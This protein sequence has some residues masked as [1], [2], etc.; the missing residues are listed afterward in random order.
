MNG[1][2]RKRGKTS[3]ELRYDLPRGADGKRRREV[4]GV[5]PEIRFDEERNDWVHGYEAPSLGGVLWSQ[6]G[7]MAVGGSRLKRW[8][9]D[10][11][12]FVIVM[13]GGLRIFLA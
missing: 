12:V 1:S 4:F 5:H 9:R 11:A 2:M 8:S 3:W 6:I 13:P 7:S 10:T